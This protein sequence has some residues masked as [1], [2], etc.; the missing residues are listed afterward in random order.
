MFEVGLVY[1][2]NS[3]QSIDLNMYQLNIDWMRFHGNRLEIGCSNVTDKTIVSDVWRSGPGDGGWY[4]G[5][6]Q[7]ILIPDFTFLL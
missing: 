1:T 5:G 2:L 3:R 4:M 7:D 6:P